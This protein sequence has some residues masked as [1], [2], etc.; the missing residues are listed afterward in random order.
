MAEPNLDPPPASLRTLGVTGGIGS[1]KT[2]VCRML[3]ALGAR[4]FYAD[5]E[6]KRLMQDDP[7]ARADLVEAFGPATFDAEG[8]LD[9]A[10]LAARVFGDD[11]ALAR[12][13]AIVHPRVFAAFEAAR[14]RAA[15]EGVRL[16]VKEAALLFE[17]GGERH[18]DAVAVVAAPVDERIAR[19][20]ARD[21][22]TPEQIRARMRHQLPQDALRAKADYVIENDGD[23][24]GLRRQVERVYRAVIHP[25]G[26]AS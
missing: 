23:L 3:E 7:G 20:E 5:L 11:A 6:A 17:V 16:L 26:S 25:E 12:L 9:R 21:G 1:G 24:D 13:N 19:V 8:R 2:T 18:L 22:A 15:A 4:V 14:A 10:R